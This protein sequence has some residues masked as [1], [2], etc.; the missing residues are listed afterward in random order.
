MLV[1][2][3]LSLFILLELF[4]YSYGTSLTYPIVYVQSICTVKPGSQVKGFNFLSGPWSPA[5]EFEA[6]VN[7]GVVSETFKRYLLSKFWPAVVL[8]KAL[9]NHFQADPV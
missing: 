6:G 9:Q 8:D 1:H 3:L 5:Q 2:W 7:S 4:R